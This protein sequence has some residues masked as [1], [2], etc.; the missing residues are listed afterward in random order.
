MPP[1]RGSKLRREA[2]TKFPRYLRTSLP[3]L[4]CLLVTVGFPVHSV[5]AQSSLPEYIEEFNV[6]TRSS[7]PLG[8]TV[9][10][11]GIVWFTE[12][13]ASKLGRFDVAN[14]TFKEYPV[15]G[16]GDMWGNTEDRNGILW[17]TQYSG[18]GSVNPGGQVVSGGHGRLLRF[19]P[20]TEMFSIVN[21]PTN[22]SFPLRITTDS[23]NRL[24]FTELLGNKI[25]MYDSSS[26][27][28]IEYEVPTYFSGPADLT[29][30][31]FGTLWFTEAY[32]QSIAEFFPKNQSFVEYHLSTSDP[33]KAISSPIGIAVSERGDVFVADHGGNWIA[34]F[35][36]SSN[37]VMHY[38]TH[39]PPKDVY[40]ISIPNG[41]LIDPAGRVW[42]CEHG[43]NSIGYLNPK[44][45][46]MVEY[47]IP[48]GPISTAL[49][50]ALAPN[51]D[52]WFTEWDANKIGVVHANLPVPLS[53]RVSET[54]LRLEQGS[55]TTLSLLTKLSE[56]LEGNGTFRYS[57]ASYNPQQVSVTFSPTYPSLSGLA[58]TPAQAQLK[59]Q[60]EISPG[61][62]ALGLGIDAGTV[63]VW[64]IIPVDVVQVVPS[65]AKLSISWLLTTGLLVVLLGAVLGVVVRR[66]SRRSV[67]KSNA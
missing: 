59:I 50:L 25:G 24:W 64:T 47:P 30:D 66:R 39:I 55:G 9:D 7:A 10:K 19:D 16:N 29:F 1:Y 52:V 37:N 45:G 46:T 48:T 23:E 42:F 51:G 44:D 43:G 12:S 63:R 58:D 67:S 41:L 18:R 14:H 57:W 60:R 6:P 3:L 62:Y 56:N 17:L 13:N 36:P 61:R 54:Y 21:I 5:R 53:V 31:R 35:D 2:T 20:K 4:A 65:N 33:S 15:P 22:S 40:P 34:Q 27:S 11:D 49:W 32:N 28:L 8:I 26:N 38:P